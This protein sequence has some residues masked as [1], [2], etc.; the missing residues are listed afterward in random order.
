[1]DHA[2]FIYGLIDP[3]LI[4]LVRLFKAT[5]KRFRSTTPTGKLV[6]NVLGSVADYA[7][8]GVMRSVSVASQVLRAD[9]RRSRLQQN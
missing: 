5:A 9:Q 6:F 7:K 3:L 8:P 2:W 4:L 1:M